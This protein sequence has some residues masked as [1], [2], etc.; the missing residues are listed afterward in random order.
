MI[1]KIIFSLICLFSLYAI[2]GN[3]FTP[4]WW[5]QNPYLAMNI[6]VE[7]AEIFEIPITAGDE[8]GIFDGPTCVG[9]ILL[10]QPIDDYPYQNVPINVSMTGG[11]V[12]GSAI[13]GHFIIFKLWKF[14][15]QVEYSYPEM[16]VQFQY[17][18]GSYNT[19]F[20]T[21]G[22]CFIDML[23]YSTPTGINAQTLTPPGGP[24]GGY[25][26]NVNFSGTEFYLNQIWINAAGGGLMKAYSFNSQTLD[27]SYNGTP[28]LYYLNY[29]WF[30]DPGSI[31]YYA[32]VTYP[33]TISFNLNNLTGI[34]E[35][36]SVLLYYRSIHGTGA[37]TFVPASYNTST[38]YLTAQVTTLG[39]F[40]VGSNDVNNTKSILEGHVYQEG[41][42][43]AISSVEVTLG[44]RTVLTDSAGY[45]CFS[46]QL[47]GEYDVY[48]VASGF[49]STIREITLL[50]NH[51]VSFDV[52]MEQESQIPTIPGQVEIIRMSTG[53]NLSWN[54]SDFA[55]SYKI[56]VSDSPNGTFQYLTQT[57]LTE[58]FLTDAFLLAQGVDPNNAFYYI[59]ADSESINRNE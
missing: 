40:I 24:G 35:P 42:S 4:A 26:N 57:S 58:I 9:A 47:P 18:M 51:I 37:F 48:Y 28:P 43:L 54:Q 2:Y 46:P 32:T 59:R 17:Y 33:I 16:S 7:A 12:P 14:A 31:S 10:T 15:T 6:F 22:T 44:S 27:L 38:G 19:T 8:I 20:V 30:I 53:F 21:Q 36:S 1:K 5:G 55:L 52:Y 11:G 29:G 49:I 13:P 34:T 25:V 39:E 50:P 41:S 23:S 3:H 45:Y 56:Y